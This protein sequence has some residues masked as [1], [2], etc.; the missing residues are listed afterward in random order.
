[1][2]PAD[3]VAVLDTLPAAKPP[4]LAIVLEAQ[5]ITRF[6]DAPADCLAELMRRQ[7]E[8]SQAMTELEEYTNRIRS[9]AV[10]CTSLS[11]I[12]SSR[13]PLGF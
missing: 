10:R 11:P 1:M 6:E 9:V 4:G 12:P 3:I 2:I 5:H 13:P 7:D 8:I